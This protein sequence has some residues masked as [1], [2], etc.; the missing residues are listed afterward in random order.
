MPG[1][2]LR[3]YSVEMA[4]RPPVLKFSTDLTVCFSN[5][6]LVPPEVTMKRLAK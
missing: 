3:R 2:F 1:I 6:T 4:P 5:G